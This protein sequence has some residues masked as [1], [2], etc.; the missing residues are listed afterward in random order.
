MDTTKPVIESY[1]VIPFWFDDHVTVMDLT[2]GEKI[3]DGFQ[4]G[5]TMGDFTKTRAWWNTNLTMEGYMPSFMPYFEGY[6]TDESYQLFSQRLMQRSTTKLVP[7]RPK[8]EVTH[9]LIA[10]NQTTHAI[11]GVYLCKPDTPEVMHFL[12]YDNALVSAVVNEENKPIKS[13]EEIERKLLTL[14][15]DGAQYV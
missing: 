2:T 5:Y 13:G 8:L 11:V 12:E 6:S 7:V 1:G 4:H 9:G 14:Y 10:I 3:A 15:W